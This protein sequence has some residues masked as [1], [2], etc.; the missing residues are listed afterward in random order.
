[1]GD[2][3]W[4]AL[5]PDMVQWRRHL[6]QHP[7]LSYQE[8][9][10]MAFVAER[11]RSFG[12]E[13]QD[14][15]GD[16]GV[17]GIIKGSLPG[18]TVALRADMDALP[19]QDEKDCEYA[20]QVPGVMHA[21]GHDGHTSGL[22]AVAR[23]FSENREKL[24]GEVRLIF[25]PGEEVC[26]GGA[27]KMI[28]AGALNGV[29]AI[30]GVHLWTPFAAGTLASA[31]GPVMA[32]TD[33]FFINITG[34]GGHGGIPHVTVDSLLI[35]AQL[36]VQLQSIIS[37]N[38]N[39]LNP[40]VLTVGTFQSGTAQNIIAE[41]CRITGTVRTFDEETRTLI[42]KRIEEVSQ[43]L[44]ALNGAEVDIEY[45]MGYPTLVN[46]AGET[47]RFFQV[48]KEMF[49]QEQVFQTPPMMPA[50]DFAY[51]VQKVPGCFIF[52]GAGNQELGAVYPHHH[53]RFDI[54][55]SAMLSAARILAAMA[56][57]F[58]NQPETE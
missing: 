20:S 42:R 58:L 1:M 46:H 55:E 54:D 24:R 34:K 47:E 16:T 56:E 13:T 39:P 45:M 8:H 33:E 41:N 44:C 43:Q 48:A 28:E 3:N 26:P 5:Y 37:R 51:Y 53:A 32:S 17:I 10:T 11:L 22:L 23:Y 19:I 57:D 27:L 6:H 4:Q 12:V 40:A 38:V 50:E 21:C 52:V 29:D 25:Q 35:G 18:K 14:G 15:V 36:V 9:Q 7:E 2:Y 30:Y 49:G 31:P